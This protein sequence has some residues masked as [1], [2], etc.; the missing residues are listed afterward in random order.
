MNDRERTQIGLNC[1]NGLGMAA[2][3]E[4]TFLIQND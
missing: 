4:L 1:Q 3:C 2:S